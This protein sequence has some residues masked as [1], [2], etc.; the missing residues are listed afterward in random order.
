MGNELSGAS[1]RGIAATSVW[2]AK[3]KDCEAEERN[4]RRSLP[5]KGERRLK[6]LGGKKERS[7]DT[8][9]S[10]EYSD[11]WT[12][13]L[14]Q[15]GNSRSD[16]CER[17]RRAHRAA[18]QALSVAYIDL[19]TIG[20]VSDP[21]NPTGPLGGLGPLPTF[22]HRTTHDVELAKF[23]MG[24]SDDDIRNLLTGLAKTRVAIV[25]ADTG[26]G[27]ST[28][29]PF[30]LMNPPP[31]AVLRL[32]DFGPI[33][34]TEPRKAAA[35]G[36][37]RFVGEAMCF[38]HD[39]RTCNDH[40][41]P[42]FPVG[43][44]VSGDRNWDSAC[45][46]I[47]VTDGTMINWVREG[48][49]ATMSTVIV[50]E[51]HERSENIDIIL[52]QLRDQVT[53][54]KHL[55]VIVTSATMDKDFFIEFFGGE[56]VVHYQYVAAQKSIGYGVPLFIGADI[57]DSVIEQGFSVEGADGA[58]VLR[59]D[60]WPEMDPATEGQEQED[61]RRNT[62]HLR[63]LRR[64]ETIPIK[65]W[66]KEMPSALA[67]QIV[68]IA[69][70][71]D[72]GDI[73]GFLPTTE[74]I[75][76]AVKAIED[77]LAKQGLDFDV[78]PL[79]S[80]VADD[81]RDKAIEAR[82]RGDK[83]KIVV[84]SNLAETSLTVKGVR[85]V[86]DS[87]LICQPEWDP[88]ITSGSFPTKPHS[89]SGVRQ[90][91]GRVG[92][93]AP[94]WV[95]P[96]YSLEQFLELPQNTPPGSTQA[97]LETFYMKLLAAGLDPDNIA[98]PANFVHPNVK[99]DADARR[100]IETFNR[101]SERARGALATSGAVDRDGHLTAFG[102]E[103]ERFPGSGAE[104]MA[105]M[106]ADQL[107]CVQEVALA[108]TVLNEG[109]LVGHDRGAIFRVA[110]VW[111]TAWRVH[112]ARCHRAFVIGCVDDLDV[113]VRVFDE[114]QAQNDPARWCANWWINHEAMGEIKSAAA[115][116]VATLSAGMKSH[117]ER[118]VRPELAGRA[119]AVM[120][121]AMG[122]LR[123]NRF[124]GNRYQN[125]IANDTETLELS[126]ARLVDPGEQII[127]LS[128]FRPPPERTS[129]EARVPFISTAIRAID[130]IDADAEGSD[131]MGF[132]LMLQTA[133]RL[134]DHNGEVFVPQ[135]PLAA[136]R[137][138]Y[139]VGASFDI[140]VGEER[141]ADILLV[142]SIVRIADQFHY[143][144]DPAA[145]NDNQS[146][147]GDSDQKI[148]RQRPSQSGFDPE[149]DPYTNSKPL[150]SEEESAQALVDVTSLE[151]NEGLLPGSTATEAFEK[152]YEAGP[153]NETKAS[154]HRL[155][156]KIEGPY[157]LRCEQIRAVVLG[158]E[159]AEGGNPILLVD[160]LA[161][162]HQRDP[163]HHPDLSY[164]DR[165][166][167]VVRG[168]VLTA[169][170]TTDRHQEL[171]LAGA[172]EFLAKPFQ[173]DELRHT[174]ESVLR[175]RNLVKTHVQV[176]QTEK[177]MHQISNR[178]HAADY[179]LSSGKAWIASQ[180]IKGALGMCRRSPPTQ[181][182]WDKMVHEFADRPGGS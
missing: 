59:F 50:D 181:E 171:V 163:S 175:Y 170:A 1:S 158:Y 39:P 121:R 72:F 85:Y 57:N 54:Y 122:S 24:L 141:S 126:R 2:T 128:S 80:T 147:R 129:G 3:C 71:T 62:R 106:L 96:L 168:L 66:K 52:A 61:L 120:T 111:P 7:G 13:R 99:Y 142:E 103:I 51:A 149:W 77:A 78:Y 90:R 31:D 82:S 63:E 8:S 19:Q 18:I 133:T 47:Y 38:G 116:L 156:L 139:P 74:S 67:E 56:E 73:L 107:A 109:R 93:D 33:I 145:S 100:N 28:L 5:A 21:N 153:R 84:S 48:R 20:T 143:P 34:V 151:T 53:R 46:L 178:V 177:A 166:K 69:A 155:F 94:G 146:G 45:Q 123:Y 140:H 40:I 88:S 112:A 157:I 49:L 35:T 159:V 92:R 102:R 118:M 30:R 25:E 105:I 160:V 180:H 29:M 81:I 17:H 165:V 132:D 70:G 110:R 137:N 169:H 79:L 26:T 167:V 95:F 174:C 44:Q 97:N 10:F 164:G 179:C 41:G 87:G 117:V 152:P 15:R 91:W 114:W 42:G 127:V 148:K 55:R 65:D 12:H 16:R 125:T 130:W 83:R 64:Q 182:E 138:D 98:L 37:A 6:G 104:A 76:V 27:K 86:V 9:T 144:G 124:D 113:L 131:E 101:E 68:K 119:R 161:E 162:Q 60:G 14:L 58:P 75:K 172:V 134:R 22:H 154:S 173:V 23:Q 150:V 108:L 32:N 135:D 115:D 176:E 43:Y 36:V 89:Q 11:D 4:G 136:V